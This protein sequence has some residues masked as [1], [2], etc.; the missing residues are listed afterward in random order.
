LADKKWAAFYEKT[1]LSRGGCP[2]FSAEKGKTTKEQRKNFP[3]KYK[4]EENE[5]KLKE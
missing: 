5:G 2:L 4:G 1:A 3:K